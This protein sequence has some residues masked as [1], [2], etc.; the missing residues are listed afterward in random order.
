MDALD[1]IA[2]KKKTLK[3]DL[4]F[5]HGQ[6]GPQT[7]K[8]ALATPEWKLVILGPN[9]AKTA[10]PSPAHRTYLFKIAADPNEKENV[11]AANPKVVAELAARL[12]EHRRLQPAG[13]VP[14]YNRGRKNFTPPKNW[15]VERK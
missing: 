14:V 3:R 13:A 4:F 10:Y 12:K 2:G 1:V 7:E 15:R 9:L 8:I 5:Y 11:A 6:A